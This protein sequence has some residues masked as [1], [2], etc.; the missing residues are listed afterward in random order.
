[1]TY[2]KVEE[3]TPIVAF[4]C[5]LATPSVVMPSSSIKVASLAMRPYMHENAHDSV[6]VSFLAWSLTT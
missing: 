3:G 6:L 2:F 5:D 4:G 1:V